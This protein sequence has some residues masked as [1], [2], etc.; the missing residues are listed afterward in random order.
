MHADEQVLDSAFFTNVAIES[1]TPELIAREFAD[2]RPHGT[3][4]FKKAK[5][6][7]TS[8]GFWG[9]DERG[10]EY[11]FVL[12]PPFNPEMNTSAEYIGSTLARMMG[13]RVPQVAIC[14]IEGTGNPQFDGRRAAAT[15]AVK[16]FRGGWKYRTFRDRRE[17]RGVRF[18]AAWLDNVDQTDQNTG[19]SEMKEGVYGYYIWDFGASLGS[20]TF[21]PKLAR[22]GWTYLWKPSETFCK[23]LRRMGLCDAPW[24]GHE[25]QFSPAVGVFSDNFDPATWRTFYPN[26]A[27]DDATT[28]DLRWAAERIVRFNDDQ[29]RAVVA[30][31]K[32]S[33]ERDADYVAQTLMARRERIRQWLLAHPAP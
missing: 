4:S 15:R 10:I 16:G 29:I 22:L 2:T 28:A 11:I 3:I 25:S 7:G 31:A 6:G 24:A 23:P 5:T 17:V 9:K 14:M 20:F 18:L 30:L 26:F 13:Y 19:L 1:Y 27:F 21:R 32:F 12:D 8:E 33:H